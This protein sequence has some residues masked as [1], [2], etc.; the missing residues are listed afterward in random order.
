MNKIFSVIEMN[1]NLF[2]VIN[3]AFDDDTRIQMYVFIYLLFVTNIGFS[4]METNI[5]QF[6]YF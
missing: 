3:L 1:M 2:I 6:I 5:Y 4:D